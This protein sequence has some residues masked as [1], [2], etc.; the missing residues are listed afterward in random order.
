[1]WERK[2]IATLIKNKNLVTMGIASFLNRI[3]RKSAARYSARILHARVLAENL[4]KKVYTQVS[5]ELFL[6]IRV[7]L[8]KI[9][10]TA[11]SKKYSL[12][13]WP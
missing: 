7:I 6:H 13:M 2:D 12:M 8:K 9:E 11:A 10:L 3:M 5:R 4:M 1:M